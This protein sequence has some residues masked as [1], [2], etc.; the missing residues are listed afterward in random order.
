MPLSPRGLFCKNVLLTSV[1]LLSALSTNEQSGKRRGGRS[2]QLR[3]N[4]GH[5]WTMS[6][7]PSAHRWPGC[8]SWLWSSR[9]QESPSFSLTCWTTERWRVTRVIVD[10]YFKRFCF[11]YFSRHFVHH[12]TMIIIPSEC[13]YNVLVM[14]CY[15]LWHFPSTHLYSFIHIFTLSYFI[16]TFSNKPFRHFWSRLQKWTYS[17]EGHQFQQ[18]PSV[19][20][21]ETHHLAF[22]K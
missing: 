22:G 21:G 15:T 20:S 7:W 14:F 19:K 1:S 3:P 17:H 18:H 12:S 10:Y 13:D 5:F 2:L 8:W 4:S 16:K 6:F 11:A 9:G